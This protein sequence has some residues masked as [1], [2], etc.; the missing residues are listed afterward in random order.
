MNEEDFI[1]D[2]AAANP[3]TAELVGGGGRV[4][5]SRKRWNNRK[6]DVD[7]QATYGCG[8]WCVAGDR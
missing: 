8:G 2:S 5:R 1:L 4:V 7:I 3:P 6:D